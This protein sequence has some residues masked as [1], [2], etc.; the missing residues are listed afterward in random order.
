MVFVQ[1]LGFIWGLGFEGS[2][3]LGP[4]PA[5][6]V[7]KQKRQ[8][9]SATIYVRNKEMRKRVVERPVLSIFRVWDPVLHIPSHQA[10]L[11]RSCPSL[12]DEDFTF[13]EVG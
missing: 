10:L 3:S 13:C 11:M 6:S 8:V 2:W 12:L 7:W 9:A 5:C 4:Q 1:S